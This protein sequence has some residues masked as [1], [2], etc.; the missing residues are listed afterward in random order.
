MPCGPRPGSLARRAW[1]IG[2]LLWVPAASR[3]PAQQPDALRA[4]AYV[5]HEVQRPDYLAELLPRGSEGITLPPPP[6]G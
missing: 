3:L 1:L 6:P 2:C 5:Y 4:P